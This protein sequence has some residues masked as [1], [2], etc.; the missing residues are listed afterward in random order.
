MLSTREKIENILKEVRPGLAMD[1]G[2]VELKSIKDG[3]VELKIKGACHGCPMAQVTFGQGVGNL[4]K[5]KIP[6][7]KEVRH[8]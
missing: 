7:V 6:E 4:I 5:Q 1:G 2:D 8:S 3:V